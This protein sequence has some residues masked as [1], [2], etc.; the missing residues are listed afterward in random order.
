MPQASPT[1]VMA[2]LDRPVVE[3]PESKDPDASDGRF[4]GLMAHFLHA[5]Q[6]AEA[7]AIPRTVASSDDEAPAEASEQPPL[8]GAAPLASEDSTARAAGQG[9]V[10]GAKGHPPATPA[11]TPTQVKVDSDPARAEAGAE[12]ASEPPLTPAPPP[13]TRA[14]RPAGPEA[15][16]SPAGITPV[17]V[18][19]LAVA[20]VVVSP[21]VVSPVAVA[22]VA[23]SPVALPPPTSGPGFAAVP[24][25]R[26]T[27]AGS[28][29]G[30]T[31]TATASIAAAPSLAE[32][33]PVL[34]SPPA[35]VTA[36]Q[37]STAMPQPGAA[38]G[39]MPPDMGDQPVQAPQAVLDDLD[40]LPSG[41]AKPAAPASRS[42]AAELPGT[43]VAAAPL[44]QTG[45]PAQ[46]PQS[47]IGAPRPLPSAPSLTS[48]ASPQPEPTVVPGPLVP[49]A[50]ADQRGKATPPAQPESAPGL[51]QGTIKVAFTQPVANPQ[52][53][54]EAS[55]GPKPP[56]PQPQT[57]AQAIASQSAATAPA[58]T[59]NQSLVPTP[60]ASFRSL[61]EERSGTADGTGAEATEAASTGRPGSVPTQVKGAV[62]GS[63]LAAATSSMTPRGSDLGLPA[64]SGTG[65]AAQ[66]AAQVGT[67]PLLLAEGP[68]APR[69]RVQPAGAQAGLAEVQ[70]A[71]TA[72]PVS[73]PFEPSAKAGG[74]DP[75]S[76]TVKTPQ[77]PE[78]PHLP[79]APTVA[80]AKTTPRALPGEAEA[81]PGQASGKVAPPL[82]ARSEVS[83][84]ITEG[85]V[86]KI[87][88]APLTPH[89]PEASS[90]TSG[91]AVAKLA[92]SAPV[93]AAPL[94]A[95]PSAPPS[96]PVIQ[97]EGSVRWMLK[98]GAQEA[99]LQL[100]P[101]SLGQVTIHLKVDGGEVHARLWVTEPTS[102]QAVRDG[103]SHLEMALREQG[104]QLGSFDLQQGQRPH[105]EAPTASAYRERALP[106]APPTRQEAPA[107]PPVSI[108]NPHHVELYA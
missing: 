34:P 32:T 99:Q 39:A 35:S 106:D 17:G 30:R 104:L 43:V 82:Q 80:A 64:G 48:T 4:A 76:Q 10:T 11:K 71:K 102:M 108:L 83:A 6:Q 85:T 41:Q 78:A 62:L 27:P 38:L 2:L 25:A 28:A 81:E 97:V 73:M 44:D 96:A 37:T 94:P 69:Q 42:A 70:S 57:S 51:P 58:T 9:A 65:T 5:P 86:P 98:G 89:A 50:P 16:G 36:R 21:V 54:T 47:P 77:A 33:E 24:G 20:P 79:Q 105:Q 61:L 84:Q 93:A 55:A 74:A 63:G 92:E 31:E 59:A 75:A 49:P 3:R 87:S 95:A 7:H 19:A 56:A 45:K 15:A 52:V 103:R 90:L 18:T 46:A 40:G 101:E 100:H 91:G 14:Q 66:Q 13:G 72:G 1:P 22:T 67:Q 60:A 68:V 26:P 23:D 107:P 53:Q 88:P 12:S 29:P 8:S